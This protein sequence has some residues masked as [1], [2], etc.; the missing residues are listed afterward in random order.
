VVETEEG[1][2][3]AARITTVTQELIWSPEDLERL[4]F[5]PDGSE[6]LRYSPHFHAIWPG[7]FR[8]NFPMT[9]M[10]VIV[11]EGKVSVKDYYGNTSCRIEVHD[12]VWCYRGTRRRPAKHVYASVHRPRADLLGRSH[13]RSREKHEQFRREARKG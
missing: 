3:M 4:W 12:Q 8:Q 5:F 7:G 9:H 2:D 6:Y 10:F 13:L 1:L 11:H